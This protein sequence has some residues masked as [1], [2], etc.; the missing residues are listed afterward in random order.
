MTESM[1]LQIRKEMFQNSGLGERKP[2]PG[3]NGKNREGVWAIA[4][5]THSYV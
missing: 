1:L 5:N 3:P 2:A 4:Q